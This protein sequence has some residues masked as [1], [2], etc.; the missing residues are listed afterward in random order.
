ME[1]RLSSSS[2]C[3][4]WHLLLIE[5]I[6]IYC[7]WKIAIYWFYWLEILPSLWIKQAKWYSFW[8][9]KKMELYR[10][11]NRRMDSHDEID[12]F[13]KV[14]T[15]NLARKDWLSAQVRIALVWR[16]KNLL[17]TS[18]LWKCIKM[19]QSCHPLHSSVW[20]LIYWAVKNLSSQRSIHVG[21]QIEKGTQLFYLDYA[22]VLTF[23]WPCVVVLKIV[24]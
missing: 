20:R 3:K 18:W 6:S 17:R 23:L 15:S 8:S 7:L 1:K 22:S 10:Q 4:W 9:I 14:N 13:T 11:A 16:R 2:S 5:Q 21:S 24:K 19:L 12:K